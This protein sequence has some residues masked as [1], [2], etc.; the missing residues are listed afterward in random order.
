M[1]RK[2]VTSAAALSVIGFLIYAGLWFWMAERIRGHIDSFV[3]DAVAEEIYIT[4]RAL[5]VRG[6]P[7]PHEVVFAGRIAHNGVTADIPLLRVRSLFLPGSALSAEAPQGIALLSPADARLWSVSSAS[8]N[9]PIPETLPADFTKEG[10]S[11]WKQQGGQ[12][13]IDHLAITKESLSLQGNGTLELDEALQP[14]GRFDARITGH[15][16]FLQWLQTNGYVETREGLLAAAVLNGLSRHD[17]ANDE[18]Y[19]TATL[20]LQNR[21]L[22]LGPLRLASLPVIR[23]AWRSQPVLPQ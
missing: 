21:T 1:I 16:A 7:G 17:Q 4:P 14:A 2:L 13:L 19:I 5:G 23:W 22:F 11:N 10:L 3:A 20:T 12:I 15:I 8:L 18:T 9:G 6:F